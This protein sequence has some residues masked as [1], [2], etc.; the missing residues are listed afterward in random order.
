[1]MRDEEKLTDWT[2]STNYYYNAHDIKTC[3]V[4]LEITVYGIEKSIYEK[5][6]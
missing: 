1:M 3:T 6:V 5:R 2:Y 4:L